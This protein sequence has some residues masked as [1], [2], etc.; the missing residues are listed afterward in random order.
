MGTENMILEYLKVLL[1]APVLF[2]VVALVVIVVFREDLK[3]L[4]LRVAKIKLPGGAEFSTPQS[5][6][7]D[8]EEARPAPEPPAEDVVQISGLPEGLSEDQRVRVEQIIRSHIATAYTWE[9][10]YLNY[11][12]ARGT[13]VVLDWLIN[14]PQ[15]TTYAH[16]DSTWLPLI[17]SA[18]ERQAII[19]ALRNHHLILQDAADMISVTA[20]GREYQQ[21]RGPLPPLTNGSTGRS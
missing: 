18:E 12:L 21:W 13:Q 16:F 15:P 3:A 17:P 7:M 5:Q 4:M 6:Q 14:L 20:K 11:F 8:A 2:S 9:Y 10:R 19:I 1:T